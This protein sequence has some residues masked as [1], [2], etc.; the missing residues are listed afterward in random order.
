MSGN[1]MVAS[2]AAKFSATISGHPIYMTSYETLRAAGK[3]LYPKALNATRHL[4]FNPIRI[5]KR[6]TLSVMG[7]T[8]L[9]DGE[10]SQTAFFD[11][12]I[13]EYR[14]D[15]KTLIQHVDPAAAGLSELE[16]EVLMAARQARPSFF[17]IEEVSPTKPQLRLRDLLEPDRPD[18]W[19]TDISL[20]DSMRVS[21]EKIAMYCRLLTVRDITMTSGFNFGFKPHRVLGILQACRQKTK[22]VPPEALAEARFIFFFQKFQAMGIELRYEDVV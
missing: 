13:Y 8:L 4:D 14:V 21:G 7:R 3:A 17:Q 11:F 2:R 19:L 15:G 22:K 5:A 18:V 6:M 12:W 16:T 20:S 10:W 1:P 9:F